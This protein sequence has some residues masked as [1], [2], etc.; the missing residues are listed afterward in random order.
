VVVLDAVVAAGDVVAVLGAAAGVLHVAVV[1]SGVPAV[2]SDA[3]VVASGVAAPDVEKPVA[4]AWA[5]SNAGHAP[6]W[7]VLRYYVRPSAGK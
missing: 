7:D 2:A 6:G 5:S 3:P 1:M 4:D